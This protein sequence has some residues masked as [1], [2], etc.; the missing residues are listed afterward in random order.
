M[1]KIPSGPVLKPLGVL[2]RAGSF[3]GLSDGQL[4]DRF[5]A[6]DR[7]VAELAFAAIVDRHGPMVRGIC[8]QVMGD[9]HD[10]Q[11]V[12]QATFLILARS[13]RSV[14]RRDSVASWLHGVA[15]RVC[16]RARL[17]NSRRRLRER[18]AA[19]LAD[20]AEAEFDESET[21]ESGELIHDE[22]ARLP[23]KFRAAVLLCD[24]QQMSYEEAARVL[25]CPVGTVKSRL[26]RGRERLRVRLVRR[27]LAPAAGLLIAPA[28]RAA[29]PSLLRDDTARTALRFTTHGPQSVAGTAATTAMALTAGMT[30][31]LLL[32][33]LKVA[34]VIIALTG[35]ATTAMAVRA[36]SGSDVANFVVQDLPRWNQVEFRGR[37]AVSLKEI[38]DA[39]SL[40]PGTRSNPTL[41]R[42][43]VGQIL[44]LYQAKGY[45]LASVALLEGGNPG[46]TRIMIEIFEGPRVKV[47]S[48]RFAGNHFASAAQLRTEIGA[49][50]PIP[51]IVGKFH[52]EMLDEDRQKLIDY[53]HSQGFFEVKITPLTQPGADQ[54]Q[55]DLT[56]VIREGRRY[57]VRGPRGTLLEPVV[58]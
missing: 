53:Y 38:E 20:A 22:L 16:L 50:K 14:R 40:R 57:P 41:A 13:A 17:A 26:A 46:D 6:E 18:Q 54:G 28:A 49:R 58:D 34:V 47:N 15:Y 21:R 4:L 23:E 24:L 9:R 1:A 37:K 48:I 42:V 19:I 29:V 5:M 39:T 25:G 7:E 2:L 55:V 45:D 27:G 44:R 8:R 32:I 35:C 36:G 12:F 43:A 51:E 11:D 10:S 56:F 31:S 3:A 33:R 30:N 52:S